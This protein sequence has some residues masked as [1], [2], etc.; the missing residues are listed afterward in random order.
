M[1]K[2]L[3]ISIVT[4]SLNQGQFIER[5][6]LS[7][8][9]QNYPNIEYIVMD[10]GS[11]DNTV[12]VLRKYEDRL[13]WKSEPDKGQSDAIN[14]GLKIATGE[15]FAWLNSDDIYQDGAIK[16]VMTYFA[17][18]PDVDMVCGDLDVIDE[19]DEII[20]QMKGFEVKSKR[21]NKMILHG[22]MAFPQPATFFR[23]RILHMVG[24]LGISY[25]YCLDVDYFVRIVNNCSVGYLNNKLAGHRYHTNSKSI[26]DSTSQTHRF[27]NERLKIIKQYSLL[28][29]YYYS[30]MW[31]LLIPIKCRLI[32]NLG[33]YSKLK[34]PP[35]AGRITINRTE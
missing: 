24:Y 1:E 23:K 5:T 30:A 25:H 2:L 18:H 6:I 4:P 32:G 35:D 22:R 12:E 33:I 15:V 14:K 17:E 34:P 28:E 13:I 3:K 26:R 7:V 27:T 11:T 8:L 29:Y 10:G 31:R 20:G 16:A 21:I 9:N 19:R